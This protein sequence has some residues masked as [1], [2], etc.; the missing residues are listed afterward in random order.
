MPF[1]PLAVISIMDLYVCELSAYIKQWCPT[2][3]STAVTK[4]LPAC[5]DT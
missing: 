4:Q 1:G 2:G 5:P 3:G